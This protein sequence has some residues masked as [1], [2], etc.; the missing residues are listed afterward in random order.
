MRPIR[1]A[2]MGGWDYV[3]MY[4]RLEVSE[5]TSVHELGSN[6]AIG[7]LTTAFFLS[8]SRSKNTWLFL[9]VIYCSWFVFSKTLL[10][11]NFLLEF[12]RVALLF[13][14]QGSTYFFCSDRTFIYYHEALS[15]SRG[16]FNFFTRL[17]SRDRFIL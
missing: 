12:F 10:L 3:E 13:I 8:L 17:F 14:C 16:F 9:T 2:C 6:P 11:K 15:L 1:H 4:Q 7:R 5:W